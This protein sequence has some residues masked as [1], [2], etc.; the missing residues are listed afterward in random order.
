M[1]KKI[2]EL[3]VKLE[4][5][6][7]DIRTLLDTF[8]NLATEAVRLNDDCVWADEHTTL[9]EALIDVAHEYDTEFA[10]VLQKRLE[11]DSGLT[12]GGLSEYKTCND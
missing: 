6:N 9:H 10:E 4:E 11:D 1:S 3:Q 2:F 7:T 12:I 8:W 5:R